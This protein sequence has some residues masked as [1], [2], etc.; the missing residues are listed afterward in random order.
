MTYQDVAHIDTRLYFIALSVERLGMRKYTPK[1]Q[2]TL[3]IPGDDDLRAPKEQE[4]RLSPVRQRIP[5][6]VSHHQ[7]THQ[8]ES[9][10]LHHLLGL[11]YSSA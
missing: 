9:L 2:G 3:G 6:T 5:A 8:S 10:I 7:I 4:K 1:V 11:Q